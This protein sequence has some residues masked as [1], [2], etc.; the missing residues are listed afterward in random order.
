MPASP[1]AVHIP[2]FERRKSSDRVH[3][4]PREVRFMREVT[5]A[6]TVSSV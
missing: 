2:E 1:V 3:P 5:N 6:A 4:C